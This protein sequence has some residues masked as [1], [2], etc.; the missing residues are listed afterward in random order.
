MDS[1]KV[2]E[3]VDLYRRYLAGLGVSPGGLS[4]PLDPLIGAVGAGSSVDADR[5]VA[6]SRQFFAALGVPEIFFG[7]DGRTTSPPAVLAH[8]CQMLP[9]MRE[10]LD[11]GRR[12]KTLRWVG[13]IRGSVR[14]VSHDPGDRDE[15]LQY[16]LA[17]LD[18][19]EA[20]LAAAD[21][22]GA[23]LRLGFVQG[24]LF[25]TGRFSIGEMADHN[26]PA[27]PEQG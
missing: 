18:E 6:D 14:S 1:V 25:A 10:F 11:Q 3:V 5:Y 2:R 8:C 26:R 19:A 15:P 4:G 21:L 16:C 23:F 13:F 20:C 17:A 24:C 27:V 12:G 7:H 22:D 9:K